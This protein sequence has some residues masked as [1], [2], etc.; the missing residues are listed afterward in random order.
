MS[1]LNIDRVFI[2][3]D[4]DVLIKCESLHDAHD[5]FKELFKSDELVN[6]DDKEDVVNNFKAKNTELQKLL[7]LCVNDMYSTSGK[8]KKPTARKLL[9]A[10]Q[11]GI[12]DFPV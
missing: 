12:V 5:T 10:C 6:F 7:Q 1:E 8:I 11:K 9:A 4:R 2:T 3:T